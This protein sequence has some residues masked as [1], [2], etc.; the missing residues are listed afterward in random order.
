MHVEDLDISPSKIAGTT[1]RIVDR[2]FEEARR[3][4]ASGC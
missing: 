4:E 2:A 3:R 1:Q